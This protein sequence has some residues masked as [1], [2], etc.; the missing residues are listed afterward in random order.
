MISF[1]L[2]DNKTTSLGLHKDITLTGWML[3]E[4]RSIGVFYSLRPYKNAVFPATFW[5]K[6]GSVGRDF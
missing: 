1:L 2:D 3:S 6:H 5:K 4:T